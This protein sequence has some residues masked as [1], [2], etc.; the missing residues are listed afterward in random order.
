VIK[1]VTG[2]EKPLSNLFVFDGRDGMGAVYLIR[3]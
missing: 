3:D 1:S 2:R